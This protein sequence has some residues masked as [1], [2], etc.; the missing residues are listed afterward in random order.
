MRIHAP[1]ALC[2]ALTITASSGCDLVA[3]VAV[4][5]SA[6][7]ASRAG[8]V[9]ESHW[10]PVF[11]GRGM[12]AT[13]L[14][15]EGL[16]SVVPENE[17]LGLQ[18]AQAYGAYAYGWM[19]NEAQDAEA[20]GD[21]DEQMQIQGRI[22]LMH[23][24]ARNLALY[25]LRRRDSGIDQAISG[26]PETLLAYLTNHYR[27]QG[28]A[29]ILFDTGYPW[30]SAIQASQG[31]PALVLDLP[32]ARVFVEYAVTLDEGVFHYGGLTMLAALQA[33]L[34]AEMGGDAARGRAMFETALERTDRHFFAVQLTYAQTY[35]VMVGDRA[36]FITLLREVIDGGDPNPESRLANRI[37]RG[38]AIRL[39]RRVDQL[40][41]Q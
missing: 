25:H 16:Y 23:E 41:A 4:N 15:L 28:D 13:I 12:P 40:F 29:A 1:V 22:R 39:L 5:Q 20:R 31:D 38:K 18:L 19:E 24:R 30:A 7:V 27:S 3:R 9:L 10:D 11:V 8:H 21:F 2:L 33:S 36:L 35:C 17:E 6:V 32:I 14:Q 37:A 26:G 34:P